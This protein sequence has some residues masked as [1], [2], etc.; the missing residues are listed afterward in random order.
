MPL[1]SS[2]WVNVILLYVEAIAFL[3]A[4]LALIVGIGILRQVSRTGR[5][6][7]FPLAPPI[8]YIILLGESV[9][10]IL[11]AGIVIASIP[12]WSQ[13]DLIAKTFTTLLTVTI[14][15]AVFLMVTS[16][17][18]KKNW[19]RFILGMIFPVISWMFI[20]I[21]LFAEPSHRGLI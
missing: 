6:R 9:W 3:S 4:F 19:Y 1:R 14:P 8:F 2:Q 16:T 18:K 10:L 21:V 7:P 15:I 13:F 12:Y 11:N 20:L 5:G 17:G